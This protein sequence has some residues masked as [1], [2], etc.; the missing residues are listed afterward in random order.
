MTVL[1]DEFLSKLGGLD[2][3]IKKLGTDDY[4]YRK[5][6]NGCIIQTGERICDMGEELEVPEPTIKLNVVLKAI[7]AEDIGSFSIGSIY[8][9]VIK[10]DTQSTTKWPSRFD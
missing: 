9:D 5:F 4:T 6:T 7:R 10:F 2:D 1:S 3:L 8:P